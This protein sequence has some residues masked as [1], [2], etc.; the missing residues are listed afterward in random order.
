MQNVF[1]NSLKILLSISLKIL[2]LRFVTALGPEH[3][4]EYP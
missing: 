3:P 4:V 2:P 1:R